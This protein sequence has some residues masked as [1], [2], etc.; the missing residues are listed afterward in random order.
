MRP[1]KLSH[2]PLPPEERESDNQKRTTWMA[3]SAPQAIYETI[4]TTALKTIAPRSVPLRYTIRVRVVHLYP[5]PLL[6]VDCIGSKCLSTINRLIGQ[7][8]R[9][10]IT[11]L[12]SIN[13]L[14][15]SNPFLNSASS[16]ALPASTDRR[17]LSPIY[18]FIVVYYIIVVA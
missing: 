14:I 2:S 3:D 16:P 11:L 5:G 15:T 7:H 13:T 8:H 18:M 9:R 6:S 4:S 10:R 12:G 17:T 1:A